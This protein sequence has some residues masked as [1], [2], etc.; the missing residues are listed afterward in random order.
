MVEW[1]ANLKQEIRFLFQGKNV[2]QVWNILVDCFEEVCVE[3]GEEKRIIKTHYD[4]LNFSMS[5][6]LKYYKIKIKGKMALCPFHNDTDPS[7]SFN[8]EKGLW[9]CFGCGAKGNVWTFVRKMEGLKN[10]D[11]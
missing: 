8:D 1:E 2:P 10:G 11:K 4:L 6:I 5:E 7:L 3:F 9:K